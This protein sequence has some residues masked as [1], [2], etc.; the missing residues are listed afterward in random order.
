M[1]HRPREGEWGIE[2]VEDERWHFLL[3]RNMNCS[4]ERLRIRK[5]GDNEIE[6]YSSND[7]GIQSLGISN[8]VSFDFIRYTVVELIEALHSGVK[9][10]AIRLSRI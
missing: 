6:Y 1:T 4:I 8:G 10:K 2:T 9:E 7:P 5:L 3:Y